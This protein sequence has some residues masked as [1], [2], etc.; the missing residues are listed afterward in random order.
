MNTRCVNIQSYRFARKCA[1]VYAV[2]P[3]GLRVTYLAPTTHVFPSA[4]LIFSNAEG[5]A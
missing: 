4:P 3:N 2:F 1:N 5:I